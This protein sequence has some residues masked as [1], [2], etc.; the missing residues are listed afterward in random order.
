M[1]AFKFNLQQLDVLGAYD[2]YTKELEE[3]KKEELYQNKL[4]DQQVDDFTRYYNPSSLRENDKPLLQGYFKSY[5]TA[6]NA[7]NKATRYG[8]VEEVNKNR[9]IMQKSIADM[10]DLYNRSVIAK[11]VAADLSSLK[12]QQR[13]GLIVIDDKNYNDNFNLFTAGSL[14]DIETS[15]GKPDTWGN[16]MTGVE[17]N[18]NKYNEAITKAKNAFNASTNGEKT[19]YIKS[20]KPTETTLVEANGEKLSVPVYEY[21]PNYKK[22][23]ELAILQ[24]EPAKAKLMQNFN[25]SMAQGGPY[26][27]S[28]R[29]TQ[30]KISKIYGVAPENITAD[31][32]LAYTIAG[33]SIKQADFK[34][35][36]AT[37]QMKQD[38]LKFEYKKNLD[39]AKM[40]LAKL[41]AANK[42]AG[43]G[44][45]VN[46]MEITL[47]K[48]YYDASKGDFTDNS[49][50][51]KPGKEVVFKSFLEGIDPK[52]IGFIQKAAPKTAT[53]I[54]EMNKVLQGYMKNPQ[55]LYAAVGG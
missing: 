22:A 24:P 33:D 23:L 52:I 7:L 37:W 25:A 10:G 34:E 50:N 35:G 19:N 21:V 27:D 47:L 14:N 8:N 28:A 5:Q 43:T 11:K 39:E 40:K 9:D 18:N 48:N 49:G 55:S 4:V 12:D 26:A 45:K 32:F 13:K 15:V 20:L 31:M 44:G 16:V 42:S 41:K 2:R 3:Q 36:K 51:I 1:A 54:K 30:D 6:A 29:I 53:D 46:N 17:Y 38:E